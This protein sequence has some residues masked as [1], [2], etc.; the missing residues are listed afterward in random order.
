[1]LKFKV[2]KTL[3]LKIASWGIPENAS[4]QTAE[5]TRLVNIISLL[6]VPLCT[7]YALLFT[8]T[9]LYPLSILFVLGIV[10]FILPLFLNKWFGLA[11]GRYFI[12]I[13]APVFFMAASIASGKDSGFYL[14]FLVISIPPVIIFPKVKTGL[15]F[16]FTTV[17]F[18]ILSIIGNVNVQPLAIIPFPM[19]MGIYLFNLFTVLATSL[20]VV[21]IF[22]TELEESKNLIQERNK[23]IID[24]INYAKKIQYTLL[25]NEELLN[26]N[27]PEH[28]VLFQPKDIVSGDFY[29][30]IHIQHESRDLFYLAVCDSTGH[31]VPGAFMSLLNISFLNEAITE[32]NIFEPHRVLEH[33][34]KRLIESISNEGQQD[35][36]DGILICFEK[37][38]NSAT[39]VK[40]TYAAANNAPILL[41]RDVINELS[42]DKMPVGKG[43]KT[44]HF[45]L[46]EL[47][48]Q[49]GDVLYLY[50]DGYADQFGGPKG[51]KLKYK[52]L[53]ELLKSNCREDAKSQKI[54][55]QNYF[56][57]WKGKLEQ[58]DDVCLIGI[59]L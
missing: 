32:R 5:Q 50:T 7:N 53:N 54:K 3:L 2:V 44:S 9:A 16:V 28:F 43:P 59:K 56:N 40:L 37:T 15:L 46:F 33:T 38:I 14:G 10:V 24:S 6:G 26:N 19:S 27:L 52:T 4:E 39:P 21:I 1:M 45:G 13:M 22:K 47:N 55:L 18:L 17:V 12:S 51:K 25:A 58:V 35:G 20:L 29:W 8:A 42:C 48:Y 34:R 41:S 49:K 11:V 36:F 30:A 57:N 23:E 31:G